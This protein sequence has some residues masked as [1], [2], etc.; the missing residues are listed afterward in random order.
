M[1]P[2]L[3]VV[4]QME[5][6][7]GD[8]LMIGRPANT[9][10]VLAPVQPRQC[11]TGPV[12]F[13]KVE[14]VVRREEIDVVLIVL[15]SVVAAVRGH[16][17][18]SFCPGQWCN[19]VAITRVLIYRAA[20]GSLPCWRCRFAAVVVT[21]VLFQADQHNAECLLLLINVTHLGGEHAHDFFK[22]VET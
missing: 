22:L 13:G 11:F 4:Q 18:P 16:G 8:P 5:L 21:P 14:L 12:K 2:K 20:V 1:V 19:R 15:L 3:H 17:S 7:I 6:G 9:K 10:V